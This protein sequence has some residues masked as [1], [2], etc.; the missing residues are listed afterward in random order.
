MIIP[1]STGVDMSDVICLCGLS[2]FVGWKMKGYL[3]WNEIN[4]KLN[5]AERLK[6]EYKAKL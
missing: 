6:N 1:I 4:K 2:F 5:E 3:G